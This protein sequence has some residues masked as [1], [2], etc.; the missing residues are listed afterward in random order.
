MIKKHIPPNQSNKTKKLSMY[1]C[2]TLQQNK[3][4]SCKDK[5]VSTSSCHNLSK[6]ALEGSVQGETNEVSVR[7][8]QNKIC[9]IS[10]FYTLKKIATAPH[11]LE[12]TCLYVRSLPG[13]Q[14]SEGSLA[15]VQNFSIYASKKFVLLNFKYLYMTRSKMMS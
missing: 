10:T 12:L 13:Y 6:F 11:I 1:W 4:I 15:S 5:I 2:N 14:A 9:P 7:C 8:S 3:E